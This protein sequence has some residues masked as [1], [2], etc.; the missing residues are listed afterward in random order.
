M[1]AKKVSLKFRF[2]SCKTLG[3]GGFLRDSGSEF[4]TEGPKTEKNFSQGLKREAKN[5]QQTGVKKAQCHRGTV[6]MEVGYIRWH[7]VLIDTLKTETSNFVL[8]P[9]FHWKP[10]ECFEQCCCTCMPELT[11]DK[12]GCMILYALK[13]I[14]FVVMDTSKKRITV[15]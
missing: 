3:A 12:S 1:N 5:G 2:K 7:T 9:S 6:W 8:N 10:V 15:V 13:L 11:E 4:Q 14:Q